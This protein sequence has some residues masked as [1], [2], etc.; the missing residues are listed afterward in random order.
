MRGPSCLSDSHRLQAHY[1]L[2]MWLVR[3]FPAVLFERY[4]DDVML[5]CR[6]QTQARVVLDTISKRLAQIGLELKLDKTRIVYW[7]DSKPQ[8]RPS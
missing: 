6:T 5:H 1:A 2:D 4:A 3:E 8:R 7:E